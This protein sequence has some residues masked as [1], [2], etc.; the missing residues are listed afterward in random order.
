[1]KRIC[2]LAALAAA[3]AIAVA[4]WTSATGGVSGPGLSAYVGL[5]NP[6]PL[7]ACSTVLTDCP[8]NT[9]AR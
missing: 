5:S 3:C 9:A 2:G 6:G 1:M 7:H 4:V 8:L